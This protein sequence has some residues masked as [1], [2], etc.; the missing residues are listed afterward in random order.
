MKTL[1]D[2][3]NSEVVSK[4]LNKIFGLSGGIVET[5]G[6]TFQGMKYDA[7]Y[8]EDDDRDG[9]WGSGETLVLINCAPVMG[10]G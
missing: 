10:I 7:D 4:K 2:F 8:F 5:P 6:G 3:K 1:Q 9:K